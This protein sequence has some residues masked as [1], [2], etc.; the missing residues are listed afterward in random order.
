[1]PTNGGRKRTNLESK[2][3]KSK[4]IKLRAKNMSIVKIAKQMKV[5]RQYVS[6]VLIEAGLGMGAEQRE[7][8]QAKIKDEMRAKE[9]QIKKESDIEKDIARLEKAGEYS[10]ASWLRFFAQR[11]K[12]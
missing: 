8:K 10:L 4:I 1:M 3:F 5:S 9:K 12:K 6:L 7:K 11:R 2:A